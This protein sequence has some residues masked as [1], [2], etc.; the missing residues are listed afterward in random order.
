MLCY[1]V[2]HGTVCVCVCIVCV[3]VTVCVWQV[4]LFALTANETGGESE[5]LLNEIIE[6]QQEINSELGFHFKYEY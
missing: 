1:Y 6:I 5:S 2:V 4:E 3:Y